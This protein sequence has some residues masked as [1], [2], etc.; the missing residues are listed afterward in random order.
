MKTNKEPLTGEIILGLVAMSLAV[1]VIANDFTAFSVALPA[2]EAEFA[3]D[4]T[5]VQWIING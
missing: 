3:T 2:I 5:T 4:I 1:L